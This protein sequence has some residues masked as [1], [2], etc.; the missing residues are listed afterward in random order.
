[1]KSDERQVRTVRISIP[2]SSFSLYPYQK[3]H[4]QRRAQDAGVSMSEYLR[5]LI[6]QDIQR[7]NG[8][9]LLAP[10]ATPSLS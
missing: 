4:L 9:R 10:V 8:I 1:M 2:T 6:E 7:T 3:E 5:E